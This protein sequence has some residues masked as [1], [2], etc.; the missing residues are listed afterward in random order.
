MWNLDRDIDAAGGD[1]VGGGSISANIHAAHC[2]GAVFSLDRVLQECACSGHARAQGR[3]LSSAP[4][5]PRL[6]GVTA[7]VCI[8][9]HITESI[10]DTIS[11]LGPLCGRTA[12]GWLYNL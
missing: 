2:R 12:R 9:L 7:I 10:P 3:V 5:A 4:P 8:A 1:L 6:A 11:G